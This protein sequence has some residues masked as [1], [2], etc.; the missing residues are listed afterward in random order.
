MK[1][2]DARHLLDAAVRKGVAFV[3]GELFYADEAGGRQELRL[4]FSSV[5][6]NRIE[7]GIKRLRG[8][9]DT[10]NSK[11]SKNNSHTPLV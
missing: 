9:F 5:P 2:M 1:G 8:A 3:P 7:E 10:C 4:C 6:T 11:P